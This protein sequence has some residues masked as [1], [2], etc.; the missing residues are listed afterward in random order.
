M[1]EYKHYLILPTLYAVLS[2]PSSQ[3]I[4][5]IGGGRTPATSWL[6]QIVQKSEKDGTGRPIWAI[7]RGV[8]ICQALS[9]PPAHLIGDGDSADSTAWTWAEEQAGIKECGPYNT[10]L[11][12]HSFRAA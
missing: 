12:L 8:N 3:E 7:D 5:C 1:H 10:A 9:H 4:V 6:T 2:C 11:L